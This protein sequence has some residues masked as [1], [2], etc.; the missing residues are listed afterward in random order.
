MTIFNSYVSL[1]EGNMTGISLEY[2]RNMTTV[3][4]R[5]IPVIPTESPHVW[6]ALNPMEITSYDNKWP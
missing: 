1:P 6:N 5:V 3:M 4:A 2:E